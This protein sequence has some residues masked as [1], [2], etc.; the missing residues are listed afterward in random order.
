[1]AH[2]LLPLWIAL[3]LPGLA[4]ARTE[5]KGRQWLAGD[6]HVHSELSMRYRPDPKAP[7]ALPMPQA[8]GDGRYTIA[9]NA[10]RA[11][12]FGL[13]WIVTADHGGPGR[14]QIAYDRA[15]PALHAARSR[16]PDVIQFYG[17]EFDTPGGDHSTLMLPIDD[18]ERTALRDYE[19]R[20]S[21]REP[22]PA[23][24]ARNTAAHGV[25]ALRY[26]A[27][28]P[29]PPILIANHPSRSAAKGEPYGLYTAAELREW[30]EIAPMVAIGMEGA[31]GHQASALRSDGGPNAHGRRGGY[32][33]Q[34]T[35][36]GFDPMT[37]RLGGLWD[38]MLGEGRRWWITASSDSHRNWRDGGNDFW[39]GEYSKTYVHARRDPADIMDGLRRGR[40]FVVTGDLITGLE[41]R[42]RIVGGRH[43]ASMGGVLTVPQA[44]KVEVTIRLTL[45]TTPNAHG[46][47]PQLDHVDL[48]GGGRPDAVR[49]D[50][51]TARL[52]H[53][54]DASEWSA[55]HNSVS[56]RWIINDPRDLRYLRLRGTSTKEREPEAD[57]EGE[58]PWRDL[59]FY[60]NPLFLGSGLA[61]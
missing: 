59:W 7:M 40:V 50:N 13:A 48:L 52:L 14:S 18:R 54:F 21:T 10:E 46:D 6:H 33:G 34:P 43:H 55:A 23:N 25:A 49:D 16:V 22:W 42:A 20:F 44:R 39:P 57:A 9:I 45:P 19:R 5:E 60:S 58:D 4:F 31:P 29:R 3:S 38:A 37:A 53:R 2:R 36:G 12:Q 27:A 56:L 1:M 11:R 8:D 24:P 35:M 30:N 28:Q 17:M 15:W 26:F 32:L 41:F 61:D 47:T 51:A